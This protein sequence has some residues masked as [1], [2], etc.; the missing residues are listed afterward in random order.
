MVKIF[1]V[2]ALSWMYLGLTAQEQKRFQQKPVE[3]IKKTQNLFN[4][5]FPG[6][7][8]VPGDSSRFLNSAYSNYKTKYFVL[9]KD[10]TG[11]NVSS[12]IYMAP[13]GRFY[14]STEN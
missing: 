13:E 12:K 6:M 7:S 9:K 11:T 3:K 10:S 14:L 1:L 2:L 4:P 5:M 8:R